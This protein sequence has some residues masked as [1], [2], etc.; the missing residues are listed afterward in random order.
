VIGSGLTQLGIW[1]LVSIVVLVQAAPA[2]AMGSAAASG[3]DISTVLNARTIFYFTPFFSLVY[4]LYSVLF[5][6]VA[7][8]CTSTEELG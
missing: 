4:T 8:T 1:V 2:L 3:F 7:V 6:V 5:A